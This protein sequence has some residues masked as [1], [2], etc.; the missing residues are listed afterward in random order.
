MLGETNSHVQFVILCVP[1]LM[2]QA[3]AGFPKLFP[4]IQWQRSNMTAS[5]YKTQNKFPLYCY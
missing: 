5:D 3:F 4:A 1:S 2:L